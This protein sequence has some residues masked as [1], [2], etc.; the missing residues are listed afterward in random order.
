MNPYFT[1][2]PPHQNY[3]PRNM[4]QDDGYSNQ[5]PMP[6]QAS[7]SNSQFA[8]PADGSSPNGQD[9]SQ[10]Q[11]HHNSNKRE[12]RRSS[13]R[14]GGMVSSSEPHVSDMPNNS[15]S[16]SSNTANKKTQGEAP[17]A[18]GSQHAAPDMQSNASS[19]QVKMEA[20]ANGSS[21]QTVTG[22]P[23]TNSG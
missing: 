15:S 16:Q 18:T 21:A 9:H 23:S 17:T 11:S 7:S 13:M 6:A 4:N 10:A 14:T 3:L 22:T 20:T 2:P 8:P 19:N 5:M 12:A 1:H